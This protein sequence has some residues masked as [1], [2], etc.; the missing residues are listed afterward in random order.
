VSI[1]TLPHYP[2][3]S[4]ATD[5]WGD[6][7]WTLFGLRLVQVFLVGLTVINLLCAIWTLR[8]AIWFGILE[9]AAR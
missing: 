3:P 9:S 5:P 1:R 4:T 2:L 7:D 6:V 8:H